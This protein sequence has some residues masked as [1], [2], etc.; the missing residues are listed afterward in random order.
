[1]AKPYKQAKKSYKK[2]K[3][4]LVLPWKIVALICAV[5][6]AVMV[7]LNIVLGMFDNT[8]SLLVAGNSFWELENKDADAVYYPGM[9]V[10]QQER[11][12]AGQALCYE[13]EAE[14]A[15]LLLNNGALPL[16]A[17]AKV[18]TLSVNSVDLTYGGTG[19]GNV[20]ASKADNLKA[21]LEKSGFE[22]NPTLWDWYSSE[23]TEDLMDAAA[24]GGTGGEN[25]TLGG[26]AP[27]REIAPANYP[28]DVKDSIASYGD[29]VI[30]TFSRVGGEGYDC[31]FPGY[32]DGDGVT[33]QMNYLALN[34]NERALMA[35]ADGLKKEGKVK[36]I[37]VLINTSN[38]LQVD[39]LKDYDVD[40][41]LWV[42]G[43]GISGTNAVTDILA[44]KVNP[45]GSLVDT[46]CYDNLSSPAMHN[47][48]AL[49]YTNFNGQVPDQASSYMVY[50]EG[51]YVGYKYYETRYFDAVMGQGNAGDYAEQY[52]KEVAFTFGY[53]LSYT[54]FE[55]G[56]MFV[57]EGVNENGEK[58]YLVSV[59]VTNTGDMAGKE[60]VQVYLSSPYTQY[61]IDNKVEKAAVQLVGF[62]KTRILEPGASET[63]T[64]Q[65]DE[66]DLASYDA[67][68]AKT[69]ILD[70]GIYY[71][72][73]ATDAHAA[74]NNILAAHGKTTADGMDAEGKS[75]LVYTWDMDFDKDTYST[76]LNGTPITNQLDHAD[77]NLYYGEDVVTFL[78][79]SD[80]SGT[81]RENIEL[82]IIEQMVDELALDRWTGIGRDFYDYPAEW[83]NL[84][85]LNAANGLTLYDMFSMDEDGDGITAAKDYDDP[86][87]TKLL[88]N[89][90]MAEL[91]SVGDCFHWRHAVPSVN[92][93]GSRDENGPQ[94]LTVSL[95]GGGLVTPE[96]E[97]AEATA[98]T[99]EDV[100]TAT[101]NTEL[102]Y[103]VGQMIAYDCL[104]ASVSCLYGPGA[105]THRTPYG[106]RNFEYYSE[107]GFL[108]GEMA[109][110][111]VSALLDH[112]ID[113][114]FK[115][116]ALNDTEQDRLGQAAWL[117]EQ[118]AREIYLKAFQKAL[119]EN[120]GRGGVMT[121]YTRWGTTWSGFNQKLMSGILRG[122]WGNQAMYITDNIL[123]QYCDASAA[124]V[125][126]GVTC[127]DAMMSYAT[128]DLKETV[129]GNEPDPIV[130]NA[131]VEAMH[132][133]LYTII[134]SAAM[135][136]VGE[137]T[138][139]K[140][141][142][143]AILRL[144]RNITWV[145][146]IV[147]AVFIVL[148]INGSRKLRKTAEYQSYKSAKQAWK[149]SKKA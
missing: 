26:Q 144:A 99:S 56:Q 125:A 16:A 9:G 35:Y 65:V 68:G 41:C 8:V 30:I 124:I 43:L 139:V 115:H 23:D 80:W 148:W 38:A 116:F 140:Q 83:E 1:M 129:G 51:I 55:Y 118:A 86:A 48:I 127:F 40:A 69:Y 3:R 24:E 31:A 119:E 77:P 134:N 34:D 81:W 111:E 107:D 45:S 33:S 94:G 74:V 136:G 110:A 93:P 32:V 46:Y 60:T 82:E 47:Y 96:G 67:Y 15:A 54:S 137:D 57:E 75:H 102:M 95:F 20:D 12:E 49:E 122:E 29:A 84:P 126:G 97:S 147:T 22:V 128:D 44:G 37:V 21:A 63:L 88:E 14:G 103:R 106:G 141:T 42:G 7:P 113:V 28:A 25:A 71:L 90:T 13:V 5:L 36:S 91:M 62:G 114:V 87:W 104:D 98:F 76:S 59:T 135:N 133:N 105:N 52:G 138:V 79:R 131:L 58:C 123:T 39:F 10:S 61:D 72:T 120:D 64:I 109:Y 117:T 149:A 78:S 50:Q 66:R 11:L 112:G 132:H 73:A 121:A 101:F 19:S 92:A 27:I 53:G 146:G 89:L 145:L 142:T 130:V 2:V 17:G 85:I 6:M 4:K 18:S 143:P 108:A 100:M 70:A